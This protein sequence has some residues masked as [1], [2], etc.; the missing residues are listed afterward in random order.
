MKVKITRST[1]TDWSDKVSFITK[2]SSPKSYLYSVSL[3]IEV[4]KAFFVDQNLSLRGSR[5]CHKTLL[6]MSYKA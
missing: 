5:L 3:M 2:L 6:Y 4:E 1:V